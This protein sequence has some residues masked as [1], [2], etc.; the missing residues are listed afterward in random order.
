MRRTPR[1]FTIP[2]G[3]PFL[4]TFTEAFTSG[5]LFDTGPLTPDAIASAR[6]FVPTR[7]AAIALTS[8]L[9]MRGT[10]LLLPTVLPLGDA[11]ALDEALPGSFGQGDHIA[12]PVIGELDRV[13]ALFKL[14]DLWRVSVASNRGDDGEPFLVASSRADAFALTSD[15]V[16]LIDETTIEDVPLSRLAEG[17]P[18]EYRPE[19]HSSYWETT[20]R[21]LRIAAE[22]YPQLLASRGLVD[23]AEALKMRTRQFAR[24]LLEHDPDAPFVIAGSTGS[25]AATS[26]LMAAVARLKM[27]AVVLPGFDR[28][29][30]DSGAWQ[31]IGSEEAE[32][33]TRFGHPQTL[34]KRTAAKIGVARDDMRRLSTYATPT[35][36]EILLAELFRPA[37]ST[38]QWSQGTLAAEI[39]TATDGMTIVTAADEREEALAIALLFRE[40]LETPGK[41]AALVTPDRTLA[42]AVQ[43]ELERWEIEVADSAGMPLALTP[44]AMLA[45]LVLEAAQPD[46]S[47]VDILAVLR[48]PLCHIGCN[49]ALRARLV[50][51][52]EI[53]GLRGKRLKTGVKGLTQVLRNA[54]VEPVTYRAPAP[55]RRLGAAIIEQ[56]LSHA[57][58]MDLAFSRFHRV[59]ATQP[60]LRTLADAHR[61]L[62]E[63]LVCAEGATPAEFSGD[64]GLALTNIFDTIAAAADEGPVIGLTDYAQIFEAMLTGHVVRPRRPGHPRLKIWGLLEARLLDAD[65][66]ILAGLD[67]GIWPPDMRGDPF[68]NR[69][70]RIA[71][72]LQPPERRIGQT[73]HDFMTLLGAPDVVITRAEKRGGTPTIASRFLRRLTAF[74]GK[75]ASERMATRGHPVIDWARALDRPERTRTIPAPAPSPPAAL[76]PTRMSL[77]EVETLYRD[78]YSIFARRVLGLDRL[79]PIDPPLDAR[80]RGTIVHEALSRFTTQY[81]VDLPPDADRQLLLSGE[82]AFAELK[83]TDPEAV[84][85]WWQRYS[86]FIPWFLGWEQQ[87]R[88][89]IAELHSEI[90][91][92]YPIKLPGG[93]V[94]TLNTRADRIEILADGSFAIIDY[95]TGTPPG[96]DEVLRGLAPQLPLT[97]ALLKRGG[98]ESLGKRDLKRGVALAYLHVARA[99]GDGDER[100]I[101][102]TKQTIQEAIEQQFD[103]LKRYIRRLMSG[104]QGYQSHRIPKSTRY[105]SDYD[106]LSRHLEWSLGGEDE[107]PFRD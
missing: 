86:N 88:L 4:E 78:P 102:P 40:A 49:E 70:M 71:L 26:E 39:E 38:G 82:A 79:E 50:D 34:L 87:R 47:G 101:T 21:F 32:L 28:D 60:T 100:A 46:A 105:R 18:Q 2:S 55:R 73:A 48:H 12:A 98:F 59:I 72:G 106:H 8:A 68:L 42:R 77:T 5:A 85:F 43:A 3:T 37:E 56:A 31:T 30:L 17:V 94:L 35:P 97:A 107:A 44:H 65:R 57:E 36:R 75:E 25:V 103:E 90:A 51:A 14:V 16:R 24:H 33:P 15:L 64:D 83:L 6:I 89:R 53:A 22:A 69:P 80:E 104:E 81:A 93:R 29:V 67:E 96:N 84:Q 62:V 1:V 11:D 9:A 10:N 19:R 74:A 95:K 63:I 99:R 41:T 58:R 66:V 91:G 20:E 52:I 54:L 61:R 27:G 92:S 45:R 7:R 76:T 23:G 13:L